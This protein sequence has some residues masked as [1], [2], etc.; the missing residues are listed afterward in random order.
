M[1]KIRI[2][3]IFKTASRIELSVSGGKDSICLNDL[4]FKLC[5]NGEIDK[6]KLTVDF[7]DE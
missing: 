1:A 3:N 5:Q 7:I 2:K 6:S 4:I